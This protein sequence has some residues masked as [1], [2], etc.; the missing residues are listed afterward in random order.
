MPANNIEE[1]WLVALG[2]RQ[3]NVLLIESAGI[4]F[5]TLSVSGSV[6]TFV[7]TIGK[8]VEWLQSR[9]RRI[10][11]T[12]TTSFGFWVHCLL[13]NISI[14]ISSWSSP[15]SLIFSLFH[16]CTA[17][18]HSML[19]FCLSQYTCTAQELLALL[20]GLGWIRIVFVQ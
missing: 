10:A 9:L 17:I 19:E 12:A 15:W 16:Y 6:D 5:C 11:I 13:I 20:P 1:N 7:F 4:L 3:R 2:N 8:Y 14:Y 18:F